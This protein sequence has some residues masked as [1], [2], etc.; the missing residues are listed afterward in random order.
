MT[1]FC[2]DPGLEPRQFMIVDVPKPGQ[3][4]RFAMPPTATVAELLA[5]VLTLF[6]KHKPVQ[7]I[8]LVASDLRGPI[9]AHVRAR[10]I[11]P[12]LLAGLL[13]DAGTFNRKN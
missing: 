3:F 6:E 8:V 12:S 10:M 5:I 7:E 4:M 1:A 9:E 13:T 11:M 2:E